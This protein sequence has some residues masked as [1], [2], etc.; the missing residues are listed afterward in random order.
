MSTVL[1]DGLNIRNAVKWI[2]D[3]IQ[4]EENGDIRLYISEAINKYDLSP[5]QADKLY[6]F[7]R[8]HLKSKK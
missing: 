6:H 7:F 1:P 4:S 3:R 2:S 8:E 5:I